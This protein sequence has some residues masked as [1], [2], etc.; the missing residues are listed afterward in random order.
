VSA[1]A[2]AEVSR[3][4]PEPDASRGGSATP[5]A[6]NSSPPTDAPSGGLHGD[7]PAASGCTFSGVLA[8]WD[9]SGETGSETSKGVATTAANITATAFT[10]GSGINATSGSGSMNSNNWPT[11]SSADATKYYTVTITPAAGCTL[12][13][14][15]V[16]I[17]AKSSASGPSTAGVGTDADQF[18]QH[19]TVSTTAPSTPALSVTGATGAVEIRVFAWSATGATGTFRVQNTFSVSGA[20]N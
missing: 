5:D 9:F 11:A 10:R 19:T 14:T 12:S 2:S 8:T 6:P 3:Q 20:L 15:S 7:A 4:T 17:D 13:L 16:A 1:C 18:A